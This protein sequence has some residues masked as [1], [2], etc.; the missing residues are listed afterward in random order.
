MN[1]VLKRF[2]KAFLS[3]GA[4]ALLVALGSAPSLTTLASLKMWLSTLAVAFISGGILAIE[5]YL[6]AQPS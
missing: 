1:I 3:G 6:Q 5:K 2:V 4:G